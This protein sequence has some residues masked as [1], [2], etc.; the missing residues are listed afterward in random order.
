MNF[1]H[2]WKKLALIYLPTHSSPNLAVRKIATGN[3]RGIFFHN[4]AHYNIVEKKVEIYM[5]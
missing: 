2:P 1:N 5:L 3:G 4:A